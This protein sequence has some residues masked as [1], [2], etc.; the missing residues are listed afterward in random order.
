M[1][2]QKVNN[3]WKPVSG[4]YRK[5]NGVWE[6][7]DAT[8]FENFVSSNV[9]MF[10]GSVD[11]NHTLTIGG[12]TSISGV[13]CSFTAI[14]DNMTNVTTAAT[15]SIVSG[16]SYATISAHTGE[17]EILSTANESNVIIQASYLNVTTTKNV[18][19]TYKAGTTSETETETITDAS[20][21]TTTTT[22]TVVTN[23]D[24]SSS[25][26]TTTVVTDESGNTIGSSE[27]NK[28]ISSDGSFN[29]TTTNYDAE[30]NATDGTNITGETNG[31]V[32]TQDVKYDESGNTIVT[33][34]D[35]DTSGNPDGTKEFRADGVNTEYYALD[36]TQ[37]FVMDIHFTI[38]F[39]SI[40]N[41][42]H[43]SQLAVMRTQQ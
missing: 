1:D 9:V 35:I 6:T 8:T 7:I 41:L 23:E 17:V 16:S 30:G 38:D 24:G 26:I 2:Y 33:G 37:G 20:G 39:T 18:T 4:Y 12:I 36:V 40:Y 3:T 5:N 14:Y 43:S 34:Y 11:G 13:S 28:D 15:W 22:T 31:N 42:V 10:G 21:N 27:S 19:L 32:S 29:A 25:V